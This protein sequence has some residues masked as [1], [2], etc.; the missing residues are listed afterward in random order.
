M[1]DTLRYFQACFGDTTGS[2]TVAIGHEPYISDAGKYGHKR[3]VEHAAHWPKRAEDAVAAML[4]Q[5]PS[6]D[7][8]CCPY[9]MRDRRRAKGNAASRVL[10]HADVDHGGLDLDVVRGLGGFALAS[11]TPGP[12]GHVYI[13]LSYAVTAAQHEMLCRGLAALL[14]GDAK[15]SDNDLLR[16]PGT[17]N[18]KAAAAGG[19]PTPV[20]W[21]VPWD[22]TRVDPRALA[23]QLGVD[24]AHAERTQPATEGSGSD[25]TPHRNSHSTTTRWSPRPSPRTTGTARPTPCASP[26]CASTQGCR[27]RRPA[28]RCAPAPIWL[29]VSTSS[30]PAANLS[31]TPKT[32]GIR[33]PRVRS[34]W[35][36]PRPQL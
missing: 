33:Q 8:Y 32:V 17:L 1:E 4:R 6:A 36:L 21:L 29:C 23:V 25:T 35:P 26:P 28:G 18:H 24:I 10:V 5:A 19:E 14:G 9:L 34:W 2:L 22:G 20:R 13:P 12:H 27:W 15:C 11:G 7:V 3:W 16:V 30:P 31:T